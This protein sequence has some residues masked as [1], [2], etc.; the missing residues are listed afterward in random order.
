[1]PDRSI[2]HFCFPYAHSKMPDFII[3]NGDRNYAQ[4][5]FL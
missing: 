5:L 3:K 1:M 2:W 4:A